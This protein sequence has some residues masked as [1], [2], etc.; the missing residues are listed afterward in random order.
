[1]SAREEIRAMVEGKPPPV[2]HAAELTAALALDTIGRKVATAYVYGR[3]P[4][5]VVDVILDDGQRIAFERF[6]DITKQQ[7]LN[8]TMVTTMGIVVALK[9][10]EAASVAAAIHRLATHHDQA[11]EDAVVGEWGSEYLRFTPS[12][13]V[14]MGDRK[15]RWDAFRA[16]GA[17]NP[18]QDAGEDRSALSY[19]ACGT[20]LVDTATETRYIRAGWFQQFV[21]REAGG[22]YNP[23]RLVQAML[24]IGWERPNSQG[25]VKATDPETGQQLAWPFFTVPAGWEPGPVI[26]GGTQPRVRTARTRVGGSPA[27]T[28]EPEEAVTPVDT[29]VTAVQ[30]AAITAEPA[31][32]D[33][34]EPRLHVDGSAYDEP[35]PWMPQRRTAA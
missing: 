3:G 1:M 30:A 32:T 6:S 26:A 13:D 8:A 7:V 29:G 11:D 9:A 22:L 27:I 12:I 4:S 2:D 5:A 34:V 35:P 33:V 18:S 23:T 14:D 21:K 16:L 25:R 28:E 31:I 20:L 15:G 17:M 24:R 10:P 19:A